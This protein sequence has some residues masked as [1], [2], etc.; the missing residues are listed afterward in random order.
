LEDSRSE[1][2][3][4]ITQRLYFTHI[5]LPESV[6]LLHFKKVLEFLSIVYWAMGILY[7]VFGGY[8]IPDSASSIALENSQSSVFRRATEVVS[9][10]SCTQK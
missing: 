6:G 8:W 7:S 3:E 1:I 2:L 4:D 5:H 9:D 10:D